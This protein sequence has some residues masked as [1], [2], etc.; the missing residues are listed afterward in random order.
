M[1]REELIQQIQAKKSMLCVGLDPVRSKM[2]KAFQESEDGIFDFCKSIIDAVASYTIAI[3]PN[4]AFFEVEGIEGWKA[5]KKVSDYLNEYYPELLLIADAKRGDIGNTSMAYAKAFFETYNCDALTVAPYMGSDSIKPFLEYP[6]RWTIVL[7][8]TS[9]TGAADFEMKKLEGGMPL[10]KEVISQVASWGGPDQLMFV[11]GATQSAYL[12][13]LREMLPEYFFLVPGVGAQG[14]SVEAVCKAAATPFGGLLI[15]ASR[16]ILYASSGNDFD[17]AA[18]AEA[19]SLQN[20][21]A[22]FL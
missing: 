22:G 18:A 12:L 17:L 13:E 11:T 1:R 4:L 9:N 7:G 20:K 10:Y 15:N 3:K 2:P 6:D 16:S 5:F 21:M 8:L 14:G 19:A